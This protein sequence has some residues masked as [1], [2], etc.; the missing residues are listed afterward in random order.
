MFGFWG[1]HDIMG[2]LERLNGTH[3]YSGSFHR[4]AAAI[5]VLA[6]TVGCTQNVE[7]GLDF[8]PGDPTPT[9]GDDAATAAGDSEGGGT[10]STGPDTPGGDEDPTAEGTDG[11]DGPASCGNGVREGN[12]S[13]DGMD[14]GEDSC[15]GFGFDDGPLSCSPQC[16][17]LTEACF[18]CGD[19]ERTLAEACDGEDFGA[20]TCVSLGFPGGSL[21]CASDCMS[22]VTD[23][24]D[25]LPNCGD[26][27][28]S[29]TEECD[30]PNLGGSSCQNLGFDEGALGCNAGACTF[31]TGAC[32]LLDC[33]H[34]GDFCLFSESNPQSTCCPGGVGGN[35]LG[36]CNLFVC[37]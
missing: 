22:V 18:S 11:D 16:T 5:W 25:P 30:G 20:E 9:A 2:Q 27:V 31:D 4:G 15:Q 6:L 10:Q 37:V 23:G 29:G 19:G 8:G 32:T 36:L 14:F 24:C 3:G 1:E 7:T 17:V 28:V 34:N 33:G 12:E 26:G 13:C 35:F 21:S